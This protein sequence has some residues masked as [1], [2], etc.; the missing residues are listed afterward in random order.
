MLLT[1]IAEE[2]RLLQHRCA[3]EWTG[4]T[5]GKRPE[6]AFPSFQTKRTVA[7]HLG[8][9]QSLCVRTEGN[10]DDHS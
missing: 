9:H 3:A 6:A 7:S 8:D 10:S 2:A 5:C 1:G 4:K